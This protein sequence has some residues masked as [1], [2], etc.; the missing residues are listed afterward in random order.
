MADRALWTGTASDLLSSLSEAVD[1]R[2][3]KAKTWPENARALSGRLRRAATFLRKIGI[4]TSFGR[5][6]RGRTRIISITTNPGQP[7]AEEGGTQP[8]ARSASSAE[9][10]KS[11]AGNG[12]AAPEPRTVVADADDVENASGETVRANPLTSSGETG[13]DDADANFPVN[14][15]REKAGLGGWKARI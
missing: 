8:S 15:G 7:R 5:Q 3:A 1:E 6:G 4:E 13:A 2:I 9:K 10:H 12:L 14:S 11:V